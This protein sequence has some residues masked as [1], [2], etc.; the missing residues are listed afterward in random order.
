MR[1]LL[2]I[3]GASLLG[4]YSVFGLH[5]YSIL[6]SRTK[7]IWVRLVFFVLA[8]ALFIFLPMTGCAFLLAAGSVPSTIGGRTAWLLTVFFCWIGPVWFYLIR[9]WTVFHSR[10][11][12]P[13]IVRFGTPRLTNR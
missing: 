1:H 10:L 8:L 3:A 13:S 4:G 12:G 5:H 6:Q 2:I 7:S 11:G 9:N